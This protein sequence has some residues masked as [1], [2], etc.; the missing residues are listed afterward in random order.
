LEK[1]NDGIR[2]GGRLVKTIKFA[3]DL[4]LIAGSSAGL[5]R[6]LSRL[7]RKVEKYGMK[8]NAT[9]TKTMSSDINVFRR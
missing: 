6:M 2:V 8:I 3:D 1:K 7:N 9:K 5:T 4:A